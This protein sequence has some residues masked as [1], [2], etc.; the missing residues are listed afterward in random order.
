[1]D[2]KDYRSEL[3]VWCE[4]WDDAQKEQ[5]HPPYSQP[6]PENIGR[7]DDTVQ[8]CYFDYL[9]QSDQVIHEEKVPNPVYPDSVGADCDFDS[10]W[11]KS[12]LV[13]DVESLKNQIFDVE[14]K[15]AKMQNVEKFS[16]KAIV[17]DPNSSSKDEK[18]MK[19]IE[20]LKKKLEKV[21]NQIG[22][23]GENSPWKI[24]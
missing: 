22:I 1:M 11:V 6:K 8:D 16:E 2:E 10:K 4:L 24:N 7:F 15:I 12:D 18:L 3:D 21:S 17:D 19:E 9:D 5:V 13:K 23:E 20:S 14:N